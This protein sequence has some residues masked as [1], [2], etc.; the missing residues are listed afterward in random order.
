[1]IKKLMTIAIILAGFSLYAN[2]NQPTWSFKT[3]NFGHSVGY[4][5]SQSCYG[6][7]CP[8]WKCD[9]GA[10]NFFQ[11]GPNPNQSFAS[12]KL[13][14]KLVLFKNFTYTN[15]DQT[16]I[17][18][19]NTTQNR[20][21]AL[22]MLK[23]SR[24]PVLCFD[25]TNS[26]DQ[27]QYRVRSWGSGMTMVTTQ[28][29]DMLHGGI[30][31][32]NP[33]NIYHGATYGTQGQNDPYVSYRYHSRD[34]HHSV[35][36]LDPSDNNWYYDNSINSADF[37]C[38][39]VPE[40]TNP[41]SGGERFF[42]VFQLAADIRGTGSDQIGHIDVTYNDGSVLLAQWELSRSD[43][44]GQYQKQTFCIEFPAAAWPNLQFRVRA[45]PTSTHNYIKVYDVW[46]FSTGPVPVG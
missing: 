42:G 46:M 18:V 6:G 19:W 7:T 39:G 20:P 45:Y 25:A 44:A 11:W 5:Y 24:T 13:G 10:Y 14:P 40:V 30:T 41:S 28:G 26:T 43:F 31:T 34:M 22:V 27:F 16:Q 23:S 9:V 8:G 29:P 33:T 21:E 4:D 37:I 38:Y 3:N 12:N 32:V 35:G 17:D 15:G 36:Q 1:M 2:V